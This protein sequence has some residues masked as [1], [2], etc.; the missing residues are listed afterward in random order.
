MTPTII[1]VFVLFSDVSLIDQFNLRA[2]FYAATRVAWLENKLYILCDDVNG[3]RNRPHD[4]IN[5]LRV[6]ADHAPYEE[7]LSEEIVFEGIKLVFGMAAS[8]STRSIFFCDVCEGCVW[9]LQI[10]KNELERFPVS[11]E[12][13]RPVK[14]SVGQDDELFVIMDTRIRRCSIDIFRLADVSLVKS[15]LLSEDIYSVSC[16]AQ[17]PNRDIVITYKTCSIPIVGLHK[18]T[19]NRWR[20]NPGIQSW[21]IRIIAAEVA[22]EGASRLL[23][24]EIYLSLIKISAWFTCWILSWLIFKLY[25]VT[26]ILSPVL[27]IYINGKQQL[28]VSE[29]LT[30]D[31]IEM[32]KEVVKPIHV[33]HLSPCNLETRKLM[34]NLQ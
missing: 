9:K 18:Y 14:L 31:P 7:L 2:G 12:S 5:R 25:R 33:F 32:D 17:S 27:I 1:L 16:V 28:L 10:P 19:V 34:K 15:I 26:E 11:H 8:V 30:S 3:P 6:F 24:L 13:K 29:G 22:S 20:N 21:I 4:K 23:I